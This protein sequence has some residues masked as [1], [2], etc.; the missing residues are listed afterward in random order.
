M[1]KTTLNNNPVDQVS[2]IV[3]LK[4]RSNDDL[5]IK[6]YEKFGNKKLAVDLKL[7]KTLDK[8]KH[9]ELAKFEKLKI[10]KAREAH[11]EKLK[12]LRIEYE[13]AQTNNEKLRIQN[14]IQ[15]EKNKQESKEAWSNFKRQFTEG[16]TLLTGLTNTLTSAL[17]AATQGIN[18]YLGAYS[19]Y[20][21]GI[22]TRIQGSGKTFAGM[23]K[24]ISTN[25]AGSPYISQV[26]TVENLSKLVDQGI[27]YNV[28]QRA[29]LQTISEKI[30]TTFDAANSALL[31]I[32]KIQQAD[33]TAARLGLEATLTNFLNANFK[34]TSYLNDS[35]R[36]VSSLLLGTSSQLGRNKSV[37][38]EYTVQKWLGSLSSVGVSDNTIQSLAQGLNYL[39]TGD[40]S[41]LSS[42]ESLQ[43]LLLMGAQLSGVDYS[44]VLTGGLTSTDANKLLSGVTRFGQ[45][46]A[47]NT[48]QVVKSQYANL[49]GLTIS[50]MTSLLNL[51]SEDL[52]NISKNMITYSSAVQEVTNQ[53]Q[54]IPNRM[55]LKDKIDTAFGNV[56]AGMGET[57]SNS[58][59]LYT[60]WILN[61]MITQSTGGGVQVPTPFI[62]PLNLNNAISAGIVG[63][64]A[65]SEIGTILSSLMS[66]Y[67]GFN[68]DNWGAAETVSKTK[69]WGFTGI[70]SKGAS[71]TSS[72]VMYISSNDSDNLLNNSIIGN[73]STETVTSSEATATESMVKSIEEASNINEILDYI[74]IISES[75]VNWGIN[76]H[77][78]KL[79]NNSILG[80]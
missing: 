33:S 21:T 36:D 23:T 4:S 38:F 6:A 22:E 56:M 71:T 44:S 54:Q 27:V 77:E 79:S 80:M 17:S 29:F 66:G 39:G 3:N 57:I 42:N 73:Q 72:R 8:Y 2:N 64:S 18:N 37:E 30:A 58:A 52:V 59:V 32:V 75:L 67:N 43:R 76:G 53:I 12:L 10:Q 55:T 63:I 11:D 7:E 69:G 16:K 68:L 28:E 24:M 78:V 31:Q 51:S 35:Y 46:I 14:Q 1:A 25:L 60:T 19:Q 47:S 13:Y 50:D 65:L 41:G 48:N 62:G 34:D 15:H 5:A 49:F 70:S 9:G 26:K 20:M 40:I 74:K 45:Q 61:E